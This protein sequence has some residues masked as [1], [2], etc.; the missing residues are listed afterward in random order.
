M[1][2][3]T[4]EDLRVDQM[5]RAYGVRTGRKQGLIPAV[6]GILAVVALLCA[7]LNCAGERPYSST[8]NFLVPKDAQMGDLYAVV[9]GV[10]KHEN[11]SVP[12]LQSAAKDAT[13]FAKFLETQKPFFRNLHLKLLVNE[14]ATRS[15]IEEGLL[16][17]LKN[18]GK[19]DAVVLYFSGHGS[20]DPIR[21]GEFFFVSYDANPKRLAA[22]AVLMS[23]QRII[24]TLD[25]RQVVVVSDTCHA[26]AFTGMKTKAVDDSL[27]KFVSQFKQS[28]GH[29]IM[30]SSRPEEYSLDAPDLNNGVFTYFLLEGLRGQ[31]DKDGDGVVGVKEAY[32]YAYE[33]TKTLTKGAQH[34]M[35][36]GRFDG[37][38]PMAF[39]GREGPQ[40]EL[41]VDPPLAEVHVKDK[42]GFKLRGKTGPDGKMTLTDMPVGQPIILMLRK[43]G[44]REYFPDPIVLSRDN[45]RVKLPPLRLEQA[46]AYLV[47]RTN[48][49]QVKVT[50][51]GKELGETGEDNLILL[52]NLQVEIP[53][54][55]LLHKEGYHD[56]KLTLTIP[57]A[58]DGKMYRCQ[59]SLLASKKP[60]P[61][62]VD[63]SVTSKPAGV[64]VYEGDSKTPLGKTDADGHCM[65][66]LKGPC[67][68]VL[69]FRKP[70]YVA[71]R[72]QVNLPEE[73]AVEVGPVV[74]ERILTRLDLSVDQP[75]AKVFM[76]HDGGDKTK[77]GEYEFAGDTDLTG[78]LTLRHLP[79]GAR[80][81]V[82]IQ[83]KGW[84]EKI[85]GP[86]VLTD[87]KPELTPSQIKLQP[88]TAALELK[89]DPP[90]SRVKIDGVE[91]GRSDREGT[92]LVKKLQVGVPHTLE[93]SKEGYQSTAIVISIPAEYEDKIYRQGKMLKLAKAGMEPSAIQLLV[94][95][96]PPGVSVFVGRNPRPDGVTDSSGRLAVDF[97]APA[98]VALR[99]EK[100]NHESKTVEYDVNPSTAG[101]FPKVTLKRTHAELVVTTKPGDVGVIIDGEYKGDTDA[102]GELQVKA[103]PVERPLKISLK[104]YGFAQEDRQVK[105]AAVAAYRMDPVMM[106]KL[107][108]KLEIMANPPVAD[109]LLKTGT[110]YQ[111]VGKTDNAGCAVVQDLP[112]GKDVYVKLR[113]AGW[114]EKIL[115]PLV[116]TPEKPSLNLAN[117]KLEPALA[118]VRFRTEPGGLKVRLNGKDTGQAVSGSSVNLKDVQVGIP[119]DLELTKE[120]YQTKVICLEIPTEYEGRAFRLDD[121]KM[122]RVVAKVHLKTNVPAAT[123]KVD[124]REVDTTKGDG[125]VTLERVAVGVPHSIQFVK[126]GYRSQALS[127]TVPVEF[128]DDIYRLKEVV[129]LEKEVAPTPAPAPAMATT[130]KSQPVDSES[131][132]PPP[133]RRPV[134]DNS[135]SEPADTQLI[136]PRKPGFP[137]DFR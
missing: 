46:I 63:V 54:E 25:A 22:T 67:K 40:V 110:Q 45:L 38:F 106:T 123:V 51:D 72:K 8:G 65:V 115:G 47:L 43:P 114:R 32:D 136:T 14:K 80:V 19:N 79:L 15:A 18:A 11:P 26:A 60:E 107:V 41:L 86:F 84:K 55:I 75:S 135:E 68:M 3:T 76:K 121:V 61:K 7:P 35:F 77:E 118:S 89:T 16:Y 39:L 34:P 101:R 73:G 13:D 130:K 120:G 92:V 9:V 96:D 2:L 87:E 99:F 91:T 108:A 95:T 71:V 6:V 81:T 70:G 44:Y 66:K 50:V 126:E 117:I 127:V 31:A 37:T 98:K 119:Y 29:V 93:F 131:Y 128:G 97:K 23:F 42:T 103:V 90:E 88:A 5:G 58:Y 134:E 105:L 21:A 4:T 24:Q 1:K 112:M 36:E 133:K 78:R 94:A 12:A 69:C 100:A 49:P 48:A 56:K 33:H 113:K 104:K 64:E 132:R 57:A 83:K 129:A 111:S 30:S 85:S 122:D 137:S 116:M 74:M 82:K 53:H 17:D 59:E 62:G 28:W 109:L 20:I 52:D 102:N 27:R 124:G 125:S 10:S